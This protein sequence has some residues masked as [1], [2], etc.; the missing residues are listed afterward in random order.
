MDSF[1][2]KVRTF[3]AFPKVD[4]EHTVRST[5]GGLLTLL[6]A[7]CGLLILWV[8]IGSYLGGY[9]DHQFMVDGEV[10]NDLAINLD[11][12]VAMPCEYLHTNVMDI[13]HDRF[14]AADL[15]NFEGINFFLPE[16]FQINSVNDHHDTPDLDEVMQELLRAEF[17]VEGVRVNED[18]PACHIFG[19]IP[20]N[21]VRGD[22][23]ITAKG[24]GYRDWAQ[25]PMEKLNFSH[26]I[27]EFSYGEFFP[28]IN[29]PLDF[30]GKVTPE[31]LQS[32]K[33]YAKVVPTY[34]ERLGILLDTN[35]YS[36]TENHR[37]YKLHNNRPTGVP[38]I[39]FKYDFE[40][41]RLLISEKR[42]PFFQFVARLGTILGGLL[43]LVGYLFRLYEKLLAILFG[44]KYVD[45]DTE[46]KHGGLLE[47]KA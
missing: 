18:A 40:P 39:F 27:L 37:A 35:Q 13:T 36:L 42:M 20:V 44:K 17:R 34:Y 28:F 38:G 3:D 31:P 26:V 41:V 19:S 43:V 14:L 33:Y 2:R 30:T 9:V 47:T 15:L 23:H 12:I 25:T 45:R 32:Y 8:E 46:K 22:F 1:S 29:N 4:A 11:M 21:Q 10:K 6:T 24:F 5:R 7:F 16:R